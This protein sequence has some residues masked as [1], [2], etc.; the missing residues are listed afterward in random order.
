MTLA[1]LET[2]W[3]VGVGVGVEGEV[4]DSDPSNG[5]PCDASNVNVGCW[6][7][8]ASSNLMSQ[9]LHMTHRYNSQNTS[10][11][12]Q[13]HSFTCNAPAVLILVMHSDQTCTE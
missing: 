13:N 5:L 10:D 12:N 6:T 1:P 4:R 3:D 8:T 7:I 11:W 9:P 2:G